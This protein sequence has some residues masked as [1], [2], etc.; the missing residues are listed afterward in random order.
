[1]IDS[2]ADEIPTRELDG[3][4]LIH[5]PKQERD[6]FYLKGVHTLPVG[7]VLFHEGHTFRVV[8]HRLS[9]DEP[10]LLILDVEM[11]GPYMH[12]VDLSLES[13]HPGR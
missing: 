5:E 7:T 9:Y 8:A 11:T 2:M 3:R 4:T 10:L 6:R 12:S 1:M 13:A